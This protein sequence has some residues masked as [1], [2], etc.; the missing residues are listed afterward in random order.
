MT[1]E[2]GELEHFN[3]AASRTVRVTLPKEVAFNLDRFGAVQKEILGKLGCQ[4]CCSGW[5]IRWDFE[6]RFIVDGGLNIR[7]F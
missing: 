6:Q 3:L 1:I 7:Q 2:K 4:A 5:D